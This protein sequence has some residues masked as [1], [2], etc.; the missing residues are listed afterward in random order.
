MCT[1][2]CSDCTILGY[3]QVLFLDNTDNWLNI[4]T[5]AVMRVVIDNFNMMAKEMERQWAEQDK[6]I[7]ME[8]QLRQSEEKVKKESQQVFRLK[9]IRTWGTLTNV[10][11]VSKN[12]VSC[13]VASTGCCIHPDPD[14]GDLPCSAQH[15][16]LLSTY[17]KDLTFIILGSLAIVAYCPPAVVHVATLRSLALPV[18][19]P[20]SARLLLGTA[21]TTTSSSSSPGSPHPLLVCLSYRTIYIY[22]INTNKRF[23]FTRHYR[24]ATALHS[25]WDIKFNIWFVFH[26]C[27]P[28]EKG[29]RN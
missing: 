14:P 9:V 22:S 27:I 3:L 15:L 21:T 13:W 19:R 23:I 4:D 16:K 11:R 12:L 18:P 26:W 6:Y 29:A 10:K 8:S 24:N 5:S 25:I 1:L 17:I 2:H 7:N 28:K 20:E